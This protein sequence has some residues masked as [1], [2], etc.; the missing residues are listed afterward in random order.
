MSDTHIDSAKGRVK[1]AAGVLSGN[2]QLKREGRVDQAKGSVKGAVDRVA[3]ALSGH[4]AD[5]KHDSND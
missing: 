2:R 1:E 3:S 4:K 5:Q